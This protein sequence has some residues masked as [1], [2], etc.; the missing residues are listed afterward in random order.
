MPRKHRRKLGVLLAGPDNQYLTTPSRTQAPTHWHWQASQ[1]NLNLNQH[2]GHGRAPATR[3]WHQYRDTV[4][5]AVSPCLQMRQAGRPI[6]FSPATGQQP[7][8]TP[9]PGVANPHS[10]ASRSSTCTSVMQIT[11]QEEQ[12]EREPG[13]SGSKHTKPQV[14][15]YSIRYRIRYPGDI[16]S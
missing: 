8:I 7:R 14:K 13:R 16:A 10:G 4:A 12:E 3:P 6:P 2:R 9:V 11:K 5:W 1:R 15:I